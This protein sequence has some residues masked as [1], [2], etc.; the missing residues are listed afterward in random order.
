MHVEPPR[1]R[2]APPTPDW[3]AALDELAAADVRLKLRTGGLEADA[4]PSA[5]EVTAFVGAALDREL[6]FKCTAGLHHALRHR[7]ATTG[8]EHHGFLGVLLATRAALDGAS[9]HEVAAALEETDPAAVLDAL[10]AAGETGLTSARRWFTGFGSCS[11]RD[12][13]DDLTELGLVTR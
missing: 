10:G 4:F 5:E 12:P 11:V 3:L 8:F 6:A 7:D 9:P 1:L 13:L 2:D